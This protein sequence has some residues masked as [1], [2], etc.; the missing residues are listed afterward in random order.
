MKE[1]LIFFICSANNRNLKYFNL[2]DIF[3][4]LTFKN[5]ICEY[6]NIDVFKH[7]ESVKAGVGQHTYSGS[8]CGGGSDG[9]T[10]SEH[11]SLSNY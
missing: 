9:F 4:Y 10:N 11:P 7:E 2:L 3:I 8:V 5:R 6:S 1:R